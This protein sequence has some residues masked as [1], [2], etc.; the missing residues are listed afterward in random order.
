MEQPRDVSFA[1][2][3]L[4]NQ[5]RRHTLGDCPRDGDITP[6][7]GRVIG[8]L[9]FHAGTD[10]YQRDLEREFDIRRSTASVIVQTMEKNGLLKREPVA[11][12]ARLKKLV[13]TPRA[14]A[15]NDQFKRKIAKTEAVITQNVSA[16]E[17]DSFFR[18]VAK[19]EDNLRKY[20]ETNQQA[21]H[22][23]EQE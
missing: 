1:V 2:R 18:V 15:F 20:T 22:G 8:H 19:F 9:S 3:A 12:D 7:Q 4:L 11:H 10:V 13:L 14:M 16:E 17:L 5:M 23:E 21:E 6:M